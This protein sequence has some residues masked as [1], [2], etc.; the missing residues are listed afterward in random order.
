MIL[1]QLSLVLV[2]N[3]LLCLGVHLLTDEGM[4]LEYPAD[5]LRAFIGDFPCK[6]LFDCLPCMASVWG[7]V[8]WYAF[9]M[10]EINP[11]VYML[12]LCGVN[13]FT[14]KIAFHD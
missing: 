3:S 14:A 9:D 7:I 10:V 13:W 5:V 8:G 6:P 12:C 4:L 1:L 2:L 11:I